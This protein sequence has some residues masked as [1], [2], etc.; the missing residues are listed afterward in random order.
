MMKDWLQFLFDAARATAPAFLIPAA[1]FWAL[2]IINSEWDI[3]YNTR[4][5]FA[6]WFIYAIVRL[7]I[8]NIQSPDWPAWWSYD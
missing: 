3:P 8:R 2:R 6:F 1:L 4:T 7:G 5:V